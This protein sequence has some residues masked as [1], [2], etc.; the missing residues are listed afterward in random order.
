MKI[1]KKL[2][3]FTVDRKIWLRGEG[4]GAS[5][6]LRESDGKKCCVGIFLGACG[7]PDRHIKGLASAN[8]IH[9][10]I[11]GGKRGPTAFLLERGNDPVAARLYNAN[12]FRYTDG[13]KRENKIKKLFHSVGVLV[14]FKG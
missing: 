6:L 7:M 12:D 8:D 11:P 14:S 3:K 2:F 10:A 9:D 5:Y 13:N 4:S 1:R